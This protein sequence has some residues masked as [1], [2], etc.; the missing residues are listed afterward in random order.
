MDERVYKGKI[1]LK[2]TRN[3]IEIDIN[4]LEVGTHK[5]PVKVTRGGKTFIQQRRLGQKEKVKESSGIEMKALKEANVKGMKPIN[6]IKSLGWD[7]KHSYFF[8]GSVPDYV[9]ICT[10][11]DKIVGITSYNVDD[12]NNFHINIIEVNGYNRRQGVGVKIMGELIKEAMKAGAETV[13]LE[14]LDEDSD[15]FYDA[16][17]MTKLVIPKATQSDMSRYEGDKEW[18]NTYLKSI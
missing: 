3:M 15:K 11:N 2:D 14:S 18:M 4:K 5:G 6:F 9:N 17:G 13:K 7:Y 10:D 16:I 1:D 8:A 12:D